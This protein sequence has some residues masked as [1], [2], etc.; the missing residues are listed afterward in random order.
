VAVASA[1]D[2][3]TDGAVRITLP[4]GKTV[5]SSDADVD[6]VL[7]DL[8]DEPVTLTATHGARRPARHSSRMTGSSGSCGWAMSSCSA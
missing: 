2:H 4:A 5:W 1:D 6:A 3:A 7:S 8:L